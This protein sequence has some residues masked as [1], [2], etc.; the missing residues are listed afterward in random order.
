VIADFDGDT[1]PDVA[2]ANKE[3]RRVSVFLNSCGSSADTRLQ[4]NVAGIFSFEEQGTLTLSIVRTG[5][6]SGTASAD[7]FTSDGTATSP[8]DYTATSGSVNLAAGDVRKDISI[9]IVDD[10]LTGGTETFNLTMANAA[11]ATIG[12]GAGAG[13]Q[14]AGLRA[15]IRAD[16]SVHDGAANQHDADS[17][18]RQTEPECRKR[19]FT[20]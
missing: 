2:L 5:D 16:V 18:C 3:Q 8:A 15:R 10:N 11:G 4:F 12:M 7:F 14:Q 13:E 17:V 1:R 9:P 19:P 6:I 20:E